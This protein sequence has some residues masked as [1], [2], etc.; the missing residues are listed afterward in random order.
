MSE[1]IWLSSDSKVEILCKFILR[2]LN[3]IVP[4]GISVFEDLR[5]ANG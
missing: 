2:H 4:V 3:S 1:W 5:T